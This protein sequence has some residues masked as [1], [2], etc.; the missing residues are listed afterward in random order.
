MPAP[1]A[2]ASIKRGRSAATVGTVRDIHSPSRTPRVKKPAR[3]VKIEAIRNRYLDQYRRA[4]N[5]SAKRSSEMDKR[6]FILK[7][8]YWLGAIFD[9]LVI[10]PMM[11]VRAA[12]AMLGIEGLSPGPDYRYAMALASALMAGWT[13]LLLWGARK[14]LERR[15]I[16]AITLLPVLS[17]MIVANIYAVVSGFVG[18][19][20][21]IPLWINQGAL[22]ALAITAL[23]LNAARKTPSPSP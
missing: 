2:K 14:P 21:M 10:I 18:I 5:G 16:I 11:S 6:L 3:R 22:L 12:R 4:E 13:V 23:A 15:G 1:E 20:S 7:L 17:G 8:T 19:G 9:A